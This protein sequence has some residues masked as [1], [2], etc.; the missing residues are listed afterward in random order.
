[1]NCS[2]GCGLAKRLVPAVVL[3]LAVAGAP[4]QG[5]AAAVSPSMT[6][7]QIVEQIQ[8]HAQAQAVQ[9]R[10]YRAIRHYQVDYR[11]LSARMD[12]EV[13]YDAVQGKSFRIVAQSGSRLLC[14]K[15]LKRALES[16][17]EAARDRALTALSEAN[18]RFQLIG[19]EAV[20]GRQAY[21]LD[22]QPRTESKFLFRGKIWVDDIDFAVVKMETEPAHNPSFW[23]SRTL[24]HC[25]N[26]KVDGFWLPR[27]VRTETKVRIGGTA[28]LSIDYGTYQVVPATLQ[29][30]IN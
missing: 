11:S 28:V 21:V 3:V 13:S 6:L 19:G 16:E 15:V 29:A 1:M 10:Q 22:A 17:M 2:L 23:I 27:Q 8:L 30:A 24:I 4:A 14:D 12:A 20:A 25:S 18:Y 5:P 26:A 9:L 7:T